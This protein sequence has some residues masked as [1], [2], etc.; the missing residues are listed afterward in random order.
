MTHSYR[1]IS[2]FC[3]LNKHHRDR[4]SYNVTSP[5]NNHFRAIGGDTALDKHLLYTVRCAGIEFGLSDHKPA[6]IDGMKTINVFIRVYRVE[7]SCFIDMLG[8]R[9]L[10]EDPVYL[11][12]FIVFIDKLKQR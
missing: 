9:Q 3:L 1:S 7:Y 11:G 2:A 12:V 6:D 10:Y 5:Y 8:E 4:F